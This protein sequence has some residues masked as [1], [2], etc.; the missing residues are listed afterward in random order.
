[1]EAFLLEVLSDFTISIPEL[2]TIAA[3]E[4]PVVVITSNRT[5]ELHDALKRRCLYHWI[6]YPDLMR[7]VQIIR[8]NAPEVTEGL[9]RAVARAVERLRDLGLGKAPG[10]AEA[11]DWARGVAVLGF[12]AL[13]EP[14]ARATL[15]WA[16]KNRDDLQLVGQRLGDVVG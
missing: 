9:A 3:D 15:G 7:E 4:P 10:P 13:D 8:T 1:F 12:E 2:G 14:T 16:V 6:E 11:I 5:R